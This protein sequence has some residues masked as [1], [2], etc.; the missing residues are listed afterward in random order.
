MRV[1]AGVRTVAAHDVI[2]VGRI[3][4]DTVAQPIEDLAQD[5]LRVNVRKAALA[6]FA[7]AA[8]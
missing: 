3:E 7:D 2:D 1:V 5:L 8:R 6:L 4:A